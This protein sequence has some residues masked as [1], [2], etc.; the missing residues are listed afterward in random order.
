M[1]SLT[2]IADGDERPA[3]WAAVISLALGVFGLVTAEFLP[4]SLLTPMAADLGVS[5]GTAGQAITATA[6]VA[7]LAGPGIVIGTR[8]MDRRRV[9]IGLTLLLALSN[10]LS[11]T[12]QSYGI[13][14]L[15]RMALGLALGGFWALSAALAMRLVPMHQL[16]RAMAIILTGVSV[17]TVC[18]APLG[19]AIGAAWGWRAAFMAAGAV[20][21][22]ALAVQVATLP[23]LPPAGAPGLRVMF[24]LTRRLRVRLALLTV[25]LAISGH[26]AG[27][28]YIRAYLEA[29]PRMSV[30]T[31]SF[32][33]LAFGIG[34]FLGNLLGGAGASRSAARTAGT[35][36][37][38]IAIT[39][40]GLV[41][42]G[43]SVPVAAGLTALW[44]MA[45][46]AL[47]VS[48]QTYMTRAAPDEA[49]SAGALLV[50]AFQIAIALGA[51]AGGL[52]TDGLGPQGAILLAGA[53]TFLGGITMFGP[54]R[55]REAVA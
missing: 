11:A 33:L 3:A 36:A 2:Q 10:I 40:F 48:L 28:T 41:T 44:G 51:V 27:F 30:E 15:A 23:T 37:F 45:F 7:M 47:P 6:L 39:A 20:G 18:A 17:A 50:S 12:A 38:A 49:E 53:A 55:L 19:A 42:L 21:L 22:V 52:L 1:T 35:A 43:A 13:L 24:G 54:G 14:L 16:A 9:V 29:V 32:V 5:S 25:V 34:G 4:V 8:R 46:G 26:F 31:I